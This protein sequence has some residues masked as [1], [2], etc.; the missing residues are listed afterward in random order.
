MFSLFQ[1]LKVLLNQPTI[2]VKKFSVRILRIISLSVKMNDADLQTVNA[3]GLMQQ[4]RDDE[5]RGALKFSRNEKSDSK[6]SILGMII[7]ARLFERTG[8]NTTALQIWSSIKGKPLFPVIAEVRLAQSESEKQSLLNRY[9]D[10]LL[11]REL[12]EA[13]R[14]AP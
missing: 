9:P 11:V 8:D 14:V 5:A 1:T 2:L 10:S 12:F 6:G 13:K 4:G 3:F 7:E